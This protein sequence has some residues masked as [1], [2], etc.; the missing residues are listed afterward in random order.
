MGRRSRRHGLKPV[1]RP[2]QAA[3]DPAG[4]R[5]A[6]AAGRLP[7]RAVL[8]LEETEEPTCTLPQS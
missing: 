1:E 5:C 8:D 6:M 3:P 2:G 7:E 4:I